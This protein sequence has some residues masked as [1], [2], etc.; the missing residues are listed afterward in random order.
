MDPVIYFLQ[1]TRI[2]R[3]LAGLKLKLQPDLNF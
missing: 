2:E 3:N 1:S